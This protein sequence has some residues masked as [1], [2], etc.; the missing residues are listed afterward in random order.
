ME[1]LQSPLKNVR[2]Y[3]SISE[4]SPG[5]ISINPIDRIYVNETF[6]SPP[7]KKVSQEQLTFNH[8]SYSTE[9]RKHAKSMSHDFRN[10]SPLSNKKSHNGEL[11][12]YNPIRSLTKKKALTNDYQKKSIKLIEEKRDYRCKALTNLVNACNQ[13]QTSRE[14]NNLIAK[15]KEVVETWSKAIDNVTKNLQKINDCNADIVHHLYYFNKF[16]NDEICKDINNL[17]LKKALPSVY[18]VKLSHP[19]TRKSSIN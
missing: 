4:M 10:G 12:L 1:L 5:F 15:E 2:P 18:S 19:S 16:S 13:V 6:H 14:L 3:S 9:R 7:V 8:R 17:K 11:L